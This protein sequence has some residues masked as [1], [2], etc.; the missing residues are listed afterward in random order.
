MAGFREAVDD[1]SLMDMG[2]T[3][4]P[5]TYEKRVAG[6]SFVRVRLDRCLADANWCSLFPGASVRHLGAAG[7]DHVPILLSLAANERQKN[8]FRYEVAWETHPDFSAKW[9][10]T[11]QMVPK[12][13]LWRL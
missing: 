13:I 8:P 6:G 1:C 3:G 9:R 4:L 11:G 2:Y 7:S 12:A 5:W 10:L